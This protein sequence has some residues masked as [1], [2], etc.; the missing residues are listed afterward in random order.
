MPACSPATATASCLYDERGRGE[1]QGAPDAI[2]WTWRRDVAAAIAWL[3]HRPD[4]D[5]PKI[6]GLG[7]ST[8]AEALVQG[9]F[10]RP[11]RRARRSGLQRTQRR[12]QPAEALA[13]LRVGVDP[14]GP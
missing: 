13:G 11:R 10:D 12:V 4:V 1:S 7:L 3:E 9:F 2:G 14:I 8:G 6:G 5:A